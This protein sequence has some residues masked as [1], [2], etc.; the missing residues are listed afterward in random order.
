M[1]NYLP[2]G[3]NVTPLAWQNRQPMQQPQQQQPNWNVNNFNPY[4][5]M[6]MQQQQQQPMQYQNMGMFGSYNPYMPRR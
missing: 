3:F 2:Q 6:M 5:N 1:P 4:Q